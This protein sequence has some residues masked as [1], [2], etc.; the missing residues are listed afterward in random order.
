MFRCL[1][2]SRKASEES[3]LDLETLSTNS[4]VTYSVKRGRVPTTVLLAQEAELAKK[5]GTH[6]V[7]VLVSGPNS[8]V[9]TV[10]LEARAIDWQLFDTEAFSFEF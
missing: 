5:N 8:L 6:S 3:K 10:F 7:K 2:Q 1:R 9:E 4:T